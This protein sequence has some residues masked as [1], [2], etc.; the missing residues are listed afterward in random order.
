[1]PDGPDDPADPGTDERPR[2]LSARE[3]GRPAADPHEGVPPHLKWLL[4]E[5]VRE[6]DRD[7]Q[8]QV[9]SAAL[10]SAGSTG[11]T[12]I[13]PRSGTFSDCCRRR[14]PRAIDQGPAGARHRATRGGIVAW[15]RPPAVGEIVHRAL[16]AR[17][18]VTGGCEGGRTV[19]VPRADG[20]GSRRGR[21]R[22]RPYRLGLHPEPGNGR[23]RCGGLGGADCRRRFARVG[24]DAALDSLGDDLGVTVDDELYGGVDD[25]LGT[26]NR[27]CGPAVN[28][29]GST[30]GTR[31]TVRAV[32]GARSARAYGDRDAAAQ[33][34]GAGQRGFGE[35]HPDHRQPLDD[36]A[37]GPGRLHISRV[38]QRQPWL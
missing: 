21:C 5:W 24:V 29:T 14:R 18:H 34:P 27:G 33:R 8:H 1:M 3:A 22:S 11:S 16:R 6:F 4:R 32:I 23:R 9:R 20:L 36:L 10:H 13:E 30:G 37:V 35:L 28:G 31:C 7:E 26:D 19:V 25:H 12:A 17:R 15:A 38:S 2:P